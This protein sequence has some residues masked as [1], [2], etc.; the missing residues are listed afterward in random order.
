MVEDM[1][2]DM[3][4]DGEDILTRME[5]MVDTD[6]VIHMEDTEDMVEAGMDQEDTDQLEE[7]RQVAR[8][9]EVVEVV[10]V[11]DEVVEADLTEL[12]RVSNYV[13]TLA[14]KQHMNCI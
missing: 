14:F 2:E 9:E 7:V 1:E 5:D 3:A 11:V 10:V 12:I 6:T 8:C 4:E 13:E